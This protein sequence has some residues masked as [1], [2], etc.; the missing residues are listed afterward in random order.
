MALITVNGQRFLSLTWRDVEEL[1]DSLF[2]KLDRD[3]RPDTIIGVMRGGMIIANLLSDLFQ[4]QEVYAIGCRSYVGKDKRE[5][6]RIYHDLVLG[7][8]KG[9]RVLLVDDVSDSGN[10]LKTAINHV[11]NPR[12]PS[13]LATAT[14]H[15]K[16]WTSYTPDYYV[17]TTDAW[18]IY[19]W[20]RVETVKILGQVFLREMESEDAV[21]EL[22]RLTRI[23]VDDVRRI[24]KSVNVGL[25]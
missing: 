14:L 9:R 8:L 22:S 25:G 24:L 21:R 5:E 11:I 4:N 12:E 15:V 13:E 19:P 1:V 6:V 17:E 7:S 16:P 10:T 3:Y 18:I 23:G 2:L 20:E